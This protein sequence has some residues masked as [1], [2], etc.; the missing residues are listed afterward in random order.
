VADADESHHFHPSGK[1]QRKYMIKQRIVSNVGTISVY[2][3]RDI[4]FFI[5]PHPS[6][7]H[8]LI[9]HKFNVV[10]SIFRILNPQTVVACGFGGVDFL[11]GRLGA[12]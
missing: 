7:L 12:M 10:L 8:L 5:L 1:K 2:K 3:F 6:S 4:L 9:S 11:G